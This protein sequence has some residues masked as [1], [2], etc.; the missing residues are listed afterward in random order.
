MNKKEVNELK[1]V[2]SDECGF[3][4]FNKVVTAYVDAEK[5]LSIII[6]SFIIQFHRICLN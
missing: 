1:K 4:N 2:F 6:I 5:I 3:M